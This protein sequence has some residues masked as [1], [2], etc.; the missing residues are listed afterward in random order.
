MPKKDTLNYKA[1]LLD[2]DGTLLDLD[3]EQFI[4]AYINALSKQFSGYLNHDDFVKH[5]FEATRVMV[6][7]NDPGKKNET[8]FYKEFCSRI[9]TSREEIQPIIDDFYQNSFPGLSGWGKILPDAKTVI[10]NALEKNM[11]LVLATNPI[12]PAS[13][14]LQRL[15]WSGLSPDVFN[16]ITTM[17]NMHYCKPNPGYYLEISQLIGCSPKRCLMAGN[18]TLED[19]VASKAGLD[20]FLVEDFILHRSDKE[21]V[22]TYRGSL[23]DLG[24]LIKDLA[25]PDDS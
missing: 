15:S 3:V 18:D 20:T 25:Y 21:P 17:E 9:G 6:E 4:P 7:N 5:L 1:L 22:S 13:A 14:I 24:S 16:L 12:F 8:V 19:L 10:D 11:I 2:L 23:R